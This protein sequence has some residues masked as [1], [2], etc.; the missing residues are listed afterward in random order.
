[1]PYKKYTED[2]KLSI[3][4]TALALG[5]PKRKDSTAIIYKV[6]GVDHRTVI[7]FSKTIDMEKLEIKIMDLKELIE[8]ELG[9][10][11]SEMNEKR[12]KATYKDL[13]VTAGILLDKAF[14][15]NGEAT[16]RTETISGNWKDLVE[17]AKNTDVPPH[18]PKSKPFKPEMEFKKDNNDL[19]Q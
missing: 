9:A 8:K 4:A 13:S 11:F 1:M 12:E 10:V 16:S 7:R 18:A 5:Y 15:L 17:A 2:E 6:L 19:E 14:I 3:V